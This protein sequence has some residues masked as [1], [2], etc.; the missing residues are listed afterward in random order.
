MLVFLI[1][2]PPLIFLLFSFLYFKIEKVID[3]IKLNYHCERNRE[4]KN[5]VINLSLIILISLICYLIIGIIFSNVYNVSLGIYFIEI[6]FLIIMTI[7]TIIFVFKQFKWEHQFEEK[8]NIKFDFFEKRGLFFYLI[9]ATLYLFFTVLVD[10][11]MYFFFTSE[12]NL[13]LFISYIVYLLLAIIIYFFIYYK[14][15]KK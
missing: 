12:F 6:L 10:I 13:L 3:N 9:P 1:I 11:F 8:Y 14:M 5:K 7:F 15:R 2:L 4:L